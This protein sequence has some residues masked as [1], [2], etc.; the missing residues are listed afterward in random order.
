M[1]IT[2][3][4]FLIILFFAACNEVSEE[5]KVKKSYDLQ[6]DIIPD[7]QRGNVTLIT[8][9]SENMN[10]SIVLPTTF[11]RKKF[12]P[13]KTEFV[14]L[15]KGEKWL[16][17]AVCGPMSRQCG[18]RRT[19]MVED[20]ITAALAAAEG[21]EAVDEASVAI[22]DAPRPHDP[23]VDFSYG[24]DDSPPQEAG[25]SDKKPK[26]K[27]NNTPPRRSTTMALTVEM[28]DK[29]RE[30]HPKSTGVRQVACYVEGDGKKEG[31]DL[32]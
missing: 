5:D 17:H 21:D 24:D 11:F 7:Y 10:N 20:L 31:L 27:N 30:K 16:T 6:I 23:M 3:F 28:P 1:K 14:R 2:K 13:E 19:K 8:R 29:C 18:L 9:S 15:K 22:D 26:K 12:P 25:D 32:A 4:L